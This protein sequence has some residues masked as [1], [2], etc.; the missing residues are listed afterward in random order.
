MDSRNRVINAEHKF[1][2]TKLFNYSKG[3]TEEHM[4]KALLEGALSYS[5]SNSTSRTTEIESLCY[6]NEAENPQKLQETPF[7]SRGFID[8]FKKLKMEPGKQKQRDTGLTCKSVRPPPRKKHKLEE[9]KT[10]QNHQWKTNLTI[11]KIPC[12][13]TLLRPR[14]LKISNSK[15]QLEKARKFKARPLNKKILESK[16]ELGLLC[17]KKRQVTIPQEFHFA[18]DERIPPRRTVNDAQLFNKI[19]LCLKSHNKKLIPRNTISRPF[20]FQTEE[21]GAQKESKF[22]VKIL[23]KQIE[24]GSSNVVTI[25]KSSTFSDLVMKER[26]RKLQHQT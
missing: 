6:L 5:P 9:A 8:T 18:I 1:S 3:D 15:E 11:P 24:E 19:T 12:L 23:H 4:N 26:R 16:G 22:V 13:Q 20:H 25:S 2:A 7:K 14:H 17:N 10:R 21:R